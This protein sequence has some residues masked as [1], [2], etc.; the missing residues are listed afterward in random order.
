MSKHLLQVL[1]LGKRSFAD[2]LRTQE[3]IRQRVIA[4][5]AG[6]TATHVPPEAQHHDYYPG[7]PSDFL[8]LVEH[9]P[10]Y[11]AGLHPFL[12][13]VYVYAVSR[14]L[15]LSSVFCWYRIHVTS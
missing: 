1:N 4:Q 13:S 5:A 12:C 6:Q 7:E 14:I 15:T 11:T 2:A 10:V 9:W 8:L 3:M